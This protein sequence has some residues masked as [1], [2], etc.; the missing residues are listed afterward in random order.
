MTDNELIRKLQALPAQR[1]AVENL[2]K[3]L[4]LLNP[5]ERMVV[6]YLLLYPKKNNIQLVC[7]KLHLEPS[8]VYRRRRLALDKL[9]S[10]LVGLE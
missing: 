1:I 3:A 2:D 8:T 5:E 6:H 4:S 7:E 10:A 9:H